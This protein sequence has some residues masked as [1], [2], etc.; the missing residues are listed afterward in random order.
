M[1]MFIQDDGIR[2]SA[3]LEKPENAEGCP[4]VIVLHGFTSSKDKGHAGSRF[5]H[6]A[7]GPVRP[8]RKRR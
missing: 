7:H 8:R 3:I 4:L 1:P 6:A 5:R 2:L